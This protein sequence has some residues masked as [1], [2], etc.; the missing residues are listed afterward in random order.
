MADIRKRP[1]PVYSHFKKV[2]EDFGDIKDSL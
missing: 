1:K 2:K